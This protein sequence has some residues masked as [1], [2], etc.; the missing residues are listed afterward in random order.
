M[1]TNFGRF[2][3]IVTLLALFGLFISETANA[4]IL[5]EYYTGYGSGVPSNPFQ[6]TYYRA[7]RLE[8]NV[9]FD[10]GTGAPG[11]AGIGDNYFAVGFRG[12]VY[13]PTT[14]NW[15]FYTQSDDGVQLYID[16]TLR[17]NN[18]ALMGGQ[19]LSSG[20]FN[21]SAGWHKV[22]LDYFEN[23]GGA[24]IRLLYEGPG[25]SKQVIPASAFDINKGVTQFQ[26]IHGRYYRWS[27][28][29]PPSP[30][31][32]GNWSMNRIDPNVNF[33]WGTGDPQL[34]N[35]VQSDTFAVWWHSNVYIPTSGNWTFYTTTDDGARLWIDGTQR[36]NQWVDQGPT[37]ASSG[38]IYL[39]AGWHNIEMQYYENTGGAVA[40]LRWEG[41][42]VSKQIIPQSNLG[43]LQGTVIAQYYN[44][45]WSG[46]QPANF[47]T[48]RYEFGIWHDWS[49]GSPE[50][51]SYTHLTLP[52]I[53]SV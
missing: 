8:S 36:I 24:V 26:G 20:A 44:A 31:T 1:N 22:N 11:I 39:D 12:M 48:E 28:G 35:W 13:I 18:W 41:P 43:I 6:T 33:Q 30:F 16:G 52:T 37:E 14:G 34:N 29:S 23:E 45:N 32:Y 51:V 42:G 50:S 7:K 4:Y 3:L 9:N 40:E 19:E 27:G 46:N 5:A 53:Y 15:T 21:L 47:A 49:T 2:V 38:A 25:V 17:I 10:W